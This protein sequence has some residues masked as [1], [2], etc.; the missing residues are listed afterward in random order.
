MPPRR[1]AVRTT[2]RMTALSPGASPPPVSMPI[3]RILFMADDSTGRR[4]RQARQPPRR[5]AAPRERQRDAEGRAVADLALE[6]E[7]AAVGADDALGDRQAESRAPLAGREEELEDPL[8]DLLAGCRRRCPRTSSSTRGP[9]RRR[10]QDHARRPAGALGRRERVLQQVEEQLLE[11]L[12]VHPDGGSRRLVR[13][14]EDRAAQRE[15]A[16]H[17]GPRALQ[18]LGG[19]HRFEP[20]RRAAGRS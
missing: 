6:R 5:A 10:A 15:L 17:D 9:S 3:L 11:L 16:R 2:A 12:F 20:Q 4:D 14:L 8:A 7:L 13:D 1:S 18:Q 19:R